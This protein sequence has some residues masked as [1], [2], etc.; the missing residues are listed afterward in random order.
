MK[1]QL[2]VYALVFSLGWSVLQAGAVLRQL[3]DEMLPVPPPK[4]PSGALAA[5]PVDWER[6]Q[7]EQRAEFAALIADELVQPERLD[8]LAD[9]VLR[10][11]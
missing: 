10:R 6:R 11:A 2:K 8:K 7:A 4:E 3:V 5:D 9:A 1:R